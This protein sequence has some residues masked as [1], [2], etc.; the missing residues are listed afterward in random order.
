MI[1][2]LKHKGVDV[3]HYGSYQPLLDYLLSID[4]YEQHRLKDSF[5]GQ[6]IYGFSFG[7]LTKP[8]IMIDA[9]IHSNHEWHTSHWLARFME[10]LIDPP[11]EF[12]NEI[13]ILKA[14][15]SFYFIPCV[16]PDG[17]DRGP[18]KGTWN[19][20]GVFI[21]QNFD[22]KWGTFESETKG[23]EPFSETEAQNIRDVIL[24][25]KPIGYLNLHRYGGGD[26]AYV[27]RPANTKYTVLL[28]DYVDTLD[29]TVPTTKQ[30]I[31]MLDRPS[32]YNWAGQQLSS[33]GQPIISSVLE[34][35]H[36][37]TTAD[38]IIQ[39]E[40]ILNGVYQFIKYVDFY[41]TKNKLIK[42]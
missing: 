7:D 36:Y 22:F 13:N 28:K 37:G 27:R 17:Y 15:Y 25:I 34:T 24:D 23:A 31:E 40:V 38:N 35:G 12:Q 14:K 2:D 3:A 1:K 33:V 42:R 32:S 20:N 8:T 41:K 4:G 10:I 5:D 39:A 19:G 29:L 9:Q 26:G 21:D 6:A 11:K 18:Q 30:W 16:N